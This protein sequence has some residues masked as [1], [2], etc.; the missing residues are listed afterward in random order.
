M[1]LFGF[2]IFAC[3]SSLLFESILAL[4]ELS[5]PKKSSSYNR[6]VLVAHFICLLLST[7]LCA[8]LV[9]VPSLYQYI[10]YVGFAGMTG[11]GGMLI[12]IATT[13]ITVRFIIIKNV[14]QR[15]QVS[16]E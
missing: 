8:E 11:G 3:I 6:L 7:N 9:V 10:F 4:R 15:N 14:L 16:G 13:L 5:V 2:H 1:P 12:I